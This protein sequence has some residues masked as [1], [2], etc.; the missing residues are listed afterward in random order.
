MPLDK[1]ILLAAGDGTRLKPITNKIPKPLINIAGKPLIN[2]ILEY[3][4]SYQVNHFIIVINPRDEK[5]FKDKIAGRDA[6]IE[7]VFQG[8]PTG[9]TDAILKARD[10]MT[11]DFIIS[12]GDMI[13]PLGHVKD[14]IEAHESSSPFATL[15]LFKA[16]VDHVEGMGNVALDENGDV[17]QIIEKPT[18]EEV[19]GPYYS[20]PFYI[21]NE[22]LVEY[23]EKCPVSKRGERELQ[24]AVQLALDDGKRVRGIPIKKNFSSDPRE[25]KKELGTIHITNPVDYFNCNLWILKSKGIEKPI[26]VLC[27]MI[28]PVIV[29]K[30]CMIAD[31]CLLG[32]NVIIENNVEIGAL[33]EISNAIISEN[34]KIGNNCYLDN[35]ILL[36]NKKIDD[37]SDIKENKGEVKIIE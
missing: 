18:K 32:P 20:F 29:G 31:D 16:S 25:F 3:L 2:W 11:G 34:C 12:A 6:R 23:L 8:K 24:D 28:E 19:I 13:T 9:M 33:T 26:D 14:M 5:L 35:V 1:A 10:Y 21:F 36:G 17:V 15:S 22:Q 4:G 30:D 7:F 27:T 37:N